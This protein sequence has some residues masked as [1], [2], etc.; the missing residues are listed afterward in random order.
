MAQWTIGRTPEEHG[1][2]SLFPFHFTSC[3]FTCSFSFFPPALRL[4]NSYN[5]A[6]LLSRNQIL[7]S[8]FPEPQANVPFSSLIFLFESS[9]PL[10]PAAPAP[11]CPRSS[12]PGIQRVFPAPRNASDE[13]WTTRGPQGTVR[14][15]DGGLHSIKRWGFTLGHGYDG[16]T[17][18]FIFL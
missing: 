12:A 3:I 9:S 8:Y 2:R 1:R 14:G 10:P 4:S 15:G 17:F 13:D 18:P 5:M 7:S 6:L 16:I 11:N